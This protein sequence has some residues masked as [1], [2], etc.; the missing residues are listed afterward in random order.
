[1]GAGL[2]D[3][4][5]KNLVREGSFCALSI[6]NFAAGDFVFRDIDSIPVLVAFEALV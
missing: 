2:L 6:S 5:M 3:T 1:V 4:P